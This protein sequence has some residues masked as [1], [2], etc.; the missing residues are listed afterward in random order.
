MHTSLSSSSNKRVIT[1]LQNIQDQ[2][3]FSSCD[4]R[5]ITVLQNIQDQM[6]CKKLKRPNDK[7]SLTT[8]KKECTGVSKNKRKNEETLDTTTYE[9]DI[10]EMFP[11]F[12]E[13]GDTFPQMSN[14]DPRNTAIIR[15][16][17]DISNYCLVDPPVL[18][19]A[20]FVV[21]N[22]QANGDTLNGSE[23]ETNN[24]TTTRADSQ[25]P[26]DFFA[27]VQFIRGA[28]LVNTS[29][30][31]VDIRVSRQ[32]SEYQVASGLILCCL[33]PYLNLI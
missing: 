2:M 7:I 15:T 1:V 12:G 33:K 26:T 13:S 21:P 23:P 18:G 14:S 19:D 31:G 11:D 3:N 20:S 32:Q 30:N 27:L 8:E 4:K 16:R 17:A 28:V 10:K 6:N 5:A 25:I 22:C 9:N 29:A 24:T